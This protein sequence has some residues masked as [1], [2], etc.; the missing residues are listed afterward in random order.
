VKVIKDDSGSINDIYVGHTTWDDY[1]EMVRSYK[2]YEFEL[3]K[4]D[5]LRATN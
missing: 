5:T 2:V 3:M 1:S 4:N